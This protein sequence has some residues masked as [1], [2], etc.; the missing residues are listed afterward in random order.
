MTGGDPS[1]RGEPTCPPVSD[2]IAAMSACNRRFPLSRLRSHGPFPLG[3][4]RAYGRS[5]LGPVPT[6]GPARSHLGACA[7]RR[8]PSHL[9]VVV[10]HDTAVCVLLHLSN[11]DAAG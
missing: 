11:A 6:Y 5:H 3:P 8:A 4:T 9:V 7:V 2:K 10:E 1:R